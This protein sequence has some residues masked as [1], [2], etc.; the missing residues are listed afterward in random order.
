ML[1]VCCVLVC[2]VRC[3]LL[4]GCRWLSIV[5]GVCCV[6]VCWLLFVGLVCCALVVVLFVVSSCLL[7]LCL[8][9]DASCFL[10]VGYALLLVVRCVC[11]SS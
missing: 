10:I 4:V 2:V 1:V 5:V 3:S 6:G 11:V 9:F 8:L 7:F